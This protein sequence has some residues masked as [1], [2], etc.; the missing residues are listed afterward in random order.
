MSLSVHYINLYSNGAFVQA[1]IARERSQSLTY[2]SPVFYDFLPL[3][4]ASSH[5]CNSHKVKTSGE[6]F[7]SI[8]CCDFG[9]KGGYWGRNS[10][11]WQSQIAC[12]LDHFDQ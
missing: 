2:T 11:Q 1:V 10:N 4:I 12:H 7:L 9:V 8:L 5:F 6:K 3:T